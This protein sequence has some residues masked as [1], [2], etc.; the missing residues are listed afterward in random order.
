M[1]VVPGRLQ[2]AQYAE[3][4]VRAAA[5]DRSEESIRQR[6]QTRLERQ[7]RVLPEAGTNFSAMIDEGALTRLVGGPAVMQ[8]QLKTLVTAPELPN[9]SI[10][11]VPF[12]AGP[13][14]TNKFIILT[15]DGPP[16]LVFLESPTGQPVLERESDLEPYHDAYAVL[17]ELALPAGGSYESLLKLQREYQT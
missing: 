16:G 13:L 1:G 17:E 2:T 12:A 7:R 8:D 11:V 10:R 4:V 14:P 3:V 5:L 6:V 9:V 15:F